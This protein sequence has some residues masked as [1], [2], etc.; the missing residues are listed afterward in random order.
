M[1]ASHFGSIGLAFGD[2]R[3]FAAAIIELA[4]V[5]PVH[6]LDADCNDLIWTDASGA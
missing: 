4:R 3:E 6:R 2:Q 5:G 1:V